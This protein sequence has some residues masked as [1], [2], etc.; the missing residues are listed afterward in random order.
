[1]F[2]GVPQDQLG[3]WTAPDG[4]QV[5]WFKVPTATWRSAARRSLDLIGG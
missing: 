3:I 2:D 5:A 1:M 4:T